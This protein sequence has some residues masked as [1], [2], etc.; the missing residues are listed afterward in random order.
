MT[1][2]VSVVAASSTATVIARL[3]VARQACKTLVPCAL[4]VHEGCLAVLAVPQ[5]LI[6]GDADNAHIR[7]GCGVSVVEEN[8]DFFERSA[9]GFRVEEI[10]DGHNAEVPVKP[11]SR[12]IPRGS[13]RGKRH[14]RYGKHNVGLPADV[15]EHDRS[16]QH[17][18]KVGKPVG[19][20]SESVGRSSGRK[21]RQ[22]DCP[23]PTHTLP[24]N[25][26]ESAVNE[27][28]DAEDSV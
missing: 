18:G 26:E 5:W 23:Q 27:N 8:V 24:A 12:N 21:R 2:R 3:V 14:L 19:G 11:V 7:V 13:A 9:P 25:C 16:D 17:N 1:G 10:D 4:L 6:V 28:E 20:R 22:F 15:E